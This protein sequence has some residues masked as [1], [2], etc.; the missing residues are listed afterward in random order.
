MT[1][2]RQS[3]TSRP[4]AEEDLF[5]YGCFGY[6]SDPPPACQFAP[7]RTAYR[8]RVLDCLSA[9]LFTCVLVAIAA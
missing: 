6:S 4:T 2:T 1:L 7:C 3:E 5:A 9:E 8:A